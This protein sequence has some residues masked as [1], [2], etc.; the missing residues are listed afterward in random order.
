MNKVFHLSY[1]DDS[2]CY[3]ACLLT[4]KGYWLVCLFNSL[5]RLSCV[6]YASNIVEV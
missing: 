5:L 4:L 3:I 2:D 6:V 1:E